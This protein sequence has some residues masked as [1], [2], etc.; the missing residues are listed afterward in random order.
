[1]RY[2]E[3]SLPS[4]IA[5]L[6]ARTMILVFAAL[7]VFGIPLSDLHVWLCLALVALFL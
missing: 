4:L 2:P 3:R 1:M 6:I 5:G 7:W